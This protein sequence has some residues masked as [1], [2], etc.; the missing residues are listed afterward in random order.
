MDTLQHMAAHARFLVGQ[1]QVILRI[2]QHFNLRHFARYFFV[3]SIIFPYAFPPPLDEA[4]L[5]IYSKICSRVLG[6]GSK[7]REL[8]GEVS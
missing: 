6:R 1:L 3:V 8:F 2:F 7:F 4:S 5:E